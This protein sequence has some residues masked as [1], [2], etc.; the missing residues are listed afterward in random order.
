MRY[1]KRRQGLFVEVKEPDYEKVAYQNEMVQH[2]RVTAKD[3]YR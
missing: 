2:F 3:N 1:K